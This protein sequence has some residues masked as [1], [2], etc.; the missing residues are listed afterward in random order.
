MEVRKNWRSRWH[1][2]IFEAET[3]QGRAFD[4]VLLVLILLSVIVV[5]M[6][7]VKSFQTNYHQ[8]LMG[9]EWVITILFTLEYIARIIT[10]PVPRR[11]IFSFFGIIDL[12]AILPTYLSLLV[13]GSQYLAIIRILR[14]LRVFRILKL[15][16]FVGASHTLAMSLRASRF[17]ITIF[18]I[19]VAIIVSIVGSVMYV[20]EGPQHGFDNI[21]TGIYWAIVTLTTVGYGDIAP[22]TALGK[23]IASFIMILGYAIIAVP[24][25]IISVEMSRQSMRTTNTEV[26]GGCGRSGHTDDAEYCRHCGTKLK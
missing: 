26:C 1:E 11:Y 25:G 9:I 18:L 8:W 12:L 10:S 7:S 20:L 2:I 16:R 6:D 19:T 4:L 22:G 21:P 5:V 13:A 23:V 14:M 17:K 15:M 24:T 3:P